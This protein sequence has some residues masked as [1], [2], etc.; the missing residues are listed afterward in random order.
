MSLGDYEKII[1]LLPDVTLTSE[2]NSELKLAS[3]LSG[4]PIGDHCVHRGQP[5]CRSDFLLLKRMLSLL[6]TLIP[7]IC[8]SRSSILLI[9][10]FEVRFPE[11]WSHGRIILP[12]ER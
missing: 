11:S 8:Y 3:K 12:Q 6:F 5:L 7:L 10:G 2:R 9:C 4:L 1:N